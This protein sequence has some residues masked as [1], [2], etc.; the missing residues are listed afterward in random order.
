MSKPVCDNLFCAISDHFICGELDTLAMHNIYPTP[1]DVVD[2]IALC[3]AKA[4]EL[5]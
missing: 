1:Q 2:Y 3:I 4:E 5:S